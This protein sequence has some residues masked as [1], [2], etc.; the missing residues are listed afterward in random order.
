MKLKNLPTPSERAFVHR[1]NHLMEEFDLLH[2]DMKRTYEFQTGLNWSNVRR[3]TPNIRNASI[4]LHGDEQPCPRALR[5]AEQLSSAFW[6]NKYFAFWVYDKYTKLDKLLQ[7]AENVNELISK[8]CGESAAHSRFQ[9][10]WRKTQYEDPAQ[11]RWSAA[12]KITS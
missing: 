8:F 6:V 3:D 1:V 10:G 5:L 9:S 12:R 11:R 4:N 7:T 2:Q